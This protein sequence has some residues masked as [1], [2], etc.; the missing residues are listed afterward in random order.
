MQ[1][2]EHTCLS[3]EGTAWF[4]TSLKDCELIRKAGRGGERN[5]E[6]ALPRVS[7]AA[8]LI[9]P[10]LLSSLGCGVIRLETKEQRHLQRP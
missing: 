3:G 10:V 8:Q 2:V 6:K 5:R 9:S 4:L 7:R 1:E